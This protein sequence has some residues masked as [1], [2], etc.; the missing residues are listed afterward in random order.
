MGAVLHYIHDKFESCSHSS[1]S[2]AGDCNTKRPELGVW[3]RCQRGPQDPAQI[4]QF[5]RARDCLKGSQEP[6]QIAV[7]STLQSPAYRCGTD[8]DGS[9]IRFLRTPVMDKQWRM[10]ASSNLAAMAVVAAQYWHGK[11][12]MS[13]FPALPGKISGFP[14]DA[15][16]GR[17]CVALLCAPQVL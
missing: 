13:S 4:A 12:N 17:G 16:R 14:A 11:K 6:V 10:P 9:Y 2:G 8:E 3:A 5:D 7:D 15:T 1:V